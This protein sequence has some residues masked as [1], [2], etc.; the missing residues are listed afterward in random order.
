M[1]QW[2]LRYLLLVASL[3]VLSYPS[4][5]LAQDE[6]R[7]SETDT[8]TVNPSLP[9]FIIVTTWGQH[10][11]DSTQ[12]VVSILGDSSWTPKRDTSDGPIREIKFAD[13]NNDGYLDLILE[14]ETFNANESSS[15]FLFNPADSMFHESAE[16]SGMTYE[17]SDNTFSQ[18]DH[19]AVEYE[20]QT[21]TLSNG[22]LKLISDEHGGPDEEYS[23]EQDGDSLTSYHRVKRTLIDTVTSDNRSEGLRIDTTW[24]LE[25]GIPRIT[26]IEKFVS[27][28]DSLRDKLNNSPLYR[29][30][31]ILGNLTHPAILFQSESRI[32]SHDNKGAYYTLSFSKAKQGKMV[33][34]KKRKVY[35]KQK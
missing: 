9:P 10:M 19:T 5:C 27:Y 25:L 33:T 32:Y 23:M 35:L 1:E 22:H 30:T 12:F 16:L 21:Y 17:S 29:E 6:D 11:N 24:D 18:G 28:P 26:Q 3:L 20:G 31:D 15:F 13:V 8:I 14:D 2:I 34:V 7:Q 4:P